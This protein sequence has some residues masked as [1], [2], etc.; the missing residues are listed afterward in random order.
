MRA[1]TRVGNRVAPSPAHKAALL[2]GGVLFTLI[3]LESTIRLFDLYPHL[4]SQD[5]TLFEY[6]EIYGWQ[7][8]PGKSALEVA[9]GEFQGMVTINSTGMR[10]EEYSVKKPFGKK[11]IAVLGDSFVANLDV[12]SSDVFT[13]RMKKL[14]PGDWQVLNFGVN[15]FGP[16]QELLMLRNKAIRYEPDMVV[17]LIYGR[18]DFDDV[19][20][21]MDWIKGYKRPKA[22]LGEDGKV[23]IDPIPAQ[24]PPPPEN[25]GGWRPSG[26]GE[27]PSIRK[28]YLRSLL[29][30]LVRDRLFYRF[31]VFLMPE[32][33]L[34]KKTPS[35]ETEVS[36]VLMKGILEGVRDFTRENG[37]ELIVVTAPTLVQVHDDVYWTKMKRKYGLSDEE[38]DLFA[39]NKFI[40]RSCR[41]LGIR[42]LDLTPEMRRRAAAGEILYY[43]H[44]QHWNKRGNQLVAEIVSDYLRGEGL[45]AHKP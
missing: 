42:S 23:A 15:G 24:P 32:I 36:Y 14:L 7:F 43:P 20:G 1:K 19:A 16:A 10:D 11:R 41:D 3:L 27:P 26:D 39:P 38:Y 22:V 8:I 17:M 5:E 28:L 4:P 30:N 18:N 13:E 9:P 29:Y 2:L 31:N 37:V 6:N 44:N 21:T 40:E 25:A 33:R 35:R 34:C 45:V 12:D